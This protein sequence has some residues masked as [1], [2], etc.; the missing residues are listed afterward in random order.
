MET[1]MVA[2]RVGGLI[3][4]VVDGET[5]ILVAADDP[6]SLAKGIL[7]FF[8]I[9]TEPGNWRSAAGNSCSSVSRCAER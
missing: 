3:D 5:G 9:P 4:S 8:A 2:T 7:I 1:P 6:A